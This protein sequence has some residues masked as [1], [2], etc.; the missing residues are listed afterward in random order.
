MEH[1]GSLSARSPRQRPGLMQLP[2]PEEERREQAQAQNAELPR[3]EAATKTA[4]SNG[5]R[6]TVIPG[7]SLLP[8][9]PTDWLQPT[10]R[11]LPSSRIAQKML[12]TVKGLGGPLLDAT[13][14]DKHGSLPRGLRAKGGTVLPSVVVDGNLFRQMKEQSLIFT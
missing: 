2:E 11:S 9:A 10:A 12:S 5:D 1:S 3:T 8:P 14:T 4:A 6:G 7:L 13:K